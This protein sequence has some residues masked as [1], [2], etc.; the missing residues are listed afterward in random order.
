M[1]TQERRSRFP[2]RIAA[3]VALAVILGVGLGGAAVPAAAQQASWQLSRRSPVRGELLTGLDGGASA[4]QLVALADSSERALLLSSSDGGANW[5]ELDGPAG[6]RRSDVRDLF[7]RPRGPTSSGAVWLAGRGDTVQVRTVES[8]AARWTRFVPPGPGSLRAAR[9]RTA[10]ELWIALELGTD[11]TLYRS[12]DGGAAWD[13]LETK[14]ALSSVRQLGPDE[15]GVWVLHASGR[16]TRLA[17]SDG[18]ITEQRSSDL[19]ASAAAFLNDRVALVVDRHGRRRLTV[20]GGQS[21]TS[22]P[23][24]LAERD[25]LIASLEVGGTLDF[26]DLEEGWLSTSGFVAH[27]NDGGLSWTDLVSS[28]GLFGRWVRDP[29]TRD[30]FTGGGQVLRSSNRGASWEA[31][32]GLDFGLTLRRSESNLFAFDR[33]PLRSQD[34]GDRWFRLDWPG[35]NDQLRDAVFASATVGFVLRPAPD[36][37]TLFRTEDTGRNWSAIDNFGP[38]RTASQLRAVTTADS[39]GGTEVRLFA[40]TE[41]GLFT[42]DDL[43][44]T[45]QLVAGY[46]GR[47]AE[48]VFFLDHE[49]GWVADGGSIFHTTDAGFTWTAAASPEPELRDLHFASPEVGFAAGAAL[50]RSSDA[51]A[52]WEEI[53]GTRSSAGAWR[54]FDSRE[55]ATIWCAGDGGRLALARD[56][57]NLL[58]IARDLELQSAPRNLAKLS[59]ADARHGVTGAGPDL[60]LLE[61]DEAGPQFRA[62]ILLHP[63][64]RYV[65][66]V[67]GA[68]EPLLG[69]SVQL[70]IRG[71]P[72]PLRFQDPAGYLYRAHQRLPDAPQSSSLQITATDLQGNLR[73]TVLPFA[74]GRRSARLSVGDA[75]VELRGPDDAWLSL[76]VDDLAELEALPDGYRALGPP[77]RAVGAA[78]RGVVTVSA[79]L[80]LARSDDGPTVEIWLDAGDRHG[81]LRSGSTLPESADAWILRAV[82][83][84][85]PPPDDPGASA[86]SPLRPNPSRRGDVLRLAPELW[87]PD[88]V[89]PARLVDAAGRVRRVTVDR[90]GVVAIPRDLPAGRYWFLLS[91]RDG[92]ETRIPLLRLP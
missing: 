7:T 11:V 42:S 63:V 51:G 92:V 77:I 21:W 43:A 15:T 89:R 59:L 18:E 14:A 30:L 31:M 50:F 75:T 33:G 28:P 23:T 47:R 52:T 81:P 3:L 91:A 9:F 19:E 36:G 40:P 57:W 8:G 84:V 2:R 62:E 35:P 74:T 10:N 70:S 90:A 49:R 45:W 71:E 73:T 34:G 76:I 83:R 16:V 61:P 54:S 1:T 26:I 38:L 48:R 27:T 41:E 67:L 80:G 79:F 5:Q 82:G 13:T 44:A 46:P 68:R 72:V 66:I 17:M 39:S 20:N 24:T 32:A 58:P 29:R 55:S 88:R 25:D 60:F 78:E 87:S 69:D 6:I 12:D 86:P 22:D 65:D 37:P 4:L 53:P 85:D 56:G 64:F